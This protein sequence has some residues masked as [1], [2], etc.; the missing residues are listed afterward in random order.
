[1]A[2]GAKVADPASAGNKMSPQQINAL[3]R[4]AV[5]KNAVEM[6]QQVGA[7]VVAGPVI[8]GNN[9]INFTPR[10]VGLCKRFILEVTGTATANTATSS[11]TVYG[12]ARLLSNVQFI[13]LNNNVRINTDGIHLTV[14]KQ[15]KAR[16]VALS[17]MPVSTIQSDAMMAGQFIASGASPNFPVIN[18][19]LP[20]VGGLP[21]R[22]VF[23][24]PLAYS[25]D[26]LRGSVY[27]NIVNSTA[28]LAVTINPSAF[29]ANAA[30]DTTA[31][32]WTSGSNPAGTI[33]NLTATLYQVYLDQ[34]P[35]GDNGVILPALDLSTIYELKVTNLTGQSVS[36]DFPYP[37]AN[38]RDFLSTLVTWNSTG[39]TAG[40]KNGSDVAY[41]ALQSANF[42]Y[43]WKI[44]AL[45]AA[46]KTREIVGSDLPLGTYY[47]SHRKKPLSTVQYGNL[48]LILN[49]ASVSAGLSYQNV[50]VE[51]FALVNALTQAGSLA[52]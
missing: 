14:L 43:L 28:T 5:L 37:Y 8:Q 47:F 15:V 35:A 1:M 44:D 3:Q 33:T 16:E 48:E 38:F 12:L 30:T 19:P 26:D 7:V 23:E 21:F 13:D 32:V 36:Q 46:Q 2:L 27:L 10:F 6:T 39:L 52:A 4:Q 34:L 29:S 18:Y 41:W 50:Y 22:A 17:S 49:A 42:T 11:A 31:S 45:L 40:L 24:I 9:I 51:D 25:D 20:T